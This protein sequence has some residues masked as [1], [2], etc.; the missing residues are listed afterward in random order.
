MEQ[1]KNVFEELEEI[2]DFDENDFA[3]LTD[4]ELEQIAGG[5]E[6]LPATKPCPV[7]GASM[8]LKGSGGHYVYFCK[9]CGKAYKVN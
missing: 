8:T 6:Q 1:E 5:A 9:P 2:M 7:C 3:E 4:E